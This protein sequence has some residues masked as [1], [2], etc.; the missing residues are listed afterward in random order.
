[1]L[2]CHHLVTTILV[3]HDSVAS[4]P[5]DLEVVVGELQA[6]DDTQVPAGLEAFENFVA[7]EVALTHPE[8]QRAVP[9][10]L[11]GWELF[12]SLLHT[13]PN[14][15]GT[16]SLD[17]ALVCALTLGCHAELTVLDADEPSLSESGCLLGGELVDVLGAVDDEGEELSSVHVG[18]P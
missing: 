12:E 16:L 10:S 6:L 8:P 18:F 9:E 15:R 14:D 7:G 5:N 17:I 2:G 4:K 1:M 3:S 13:E 11:A